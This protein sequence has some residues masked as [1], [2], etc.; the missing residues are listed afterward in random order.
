[1]ISVDSYLQKSRGVFGALSNCIIFLKNQC[2][3]LLRLCLLPYEM[4]WR[5][6]ESRSYMGIVKIIKC[7]KVDGI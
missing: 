4:H 5:F 7:E 6:F 3:N 2:D 1:M